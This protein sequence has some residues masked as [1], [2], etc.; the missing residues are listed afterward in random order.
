LLIFSSLTTKDVSFD[1]D[2]IVRVQNRYLKKNAAPLSSCFFF[3]AKILFL[4]FVKTATN[5]MRCP[6]FC[7]SWTPEGRRLITGSSARSLCALYAPKEF[8][9][10]R[11]FVKNNIVI[12]FV[13]SSAADRDPGSGAFLPP[14]SERIFFREPG[15]GPFFGEIFLYYLQNSC[16]VIFM[17]LGYS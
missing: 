13:Y 10:K 6:I 5:K 2:R 3:Q 1:S 15:C 17:K 11:G 4:R 9:R 12:L 8:R 7:L 14:G 16:Y